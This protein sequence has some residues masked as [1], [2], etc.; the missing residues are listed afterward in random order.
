MKDVFIS[1]HTESA[2]QVVENIARLLEERGVSCWYAPR[3]CEN[4]WADAIV[5]AIDTAEIFLVLLNSGSCNSEHVKN[6]IHVAYEN[7]CH[8]KNRIIAFQLEDQCLSNATIRYY[9]GR[10]HVLNGVFP[11]LDDRI[12]ELVNRVIYIKNHRSEPEAGAECGFFVPSPVTPVVNFVGRRQE[13]SELG[14]LVE[15][16]GKVFVSGMGGIGKSE[17]VR[18]FVSENKKKFSCIMW[19]GFKDSLRSLFVE[20]GVVNIAGF[21]RDPPEESDES[22]FRRKLD[23][24]AKHGRSD[25]LLVIDNFD[26]DGDPDLERIL[27]LPISVI[28]TTRN[29]QYDSEL[30]Y[31]KLKPMQ[32][33][34]DLLTLFGKGYPKR[35]SE[36]DTETVMELIEALGRHT[37]AIRLISNHM[38]QQRIKPEKMLDTVL[39]NVN[40]GSSG[41]GAIYS[42]FEMSALSENERRILINLALIPA[43]G[44]A[45]EELA[46]ALGLDDYEDINALI[47]KSWLVYD[48]ASDYIALHPI[49][50]QLT[51]EKIGYSDEACGNYLQFMTDIARGAKYIE[52]E[53]RGEIT[54]RIE[55][56]LAV[57]PCDSEY[58]VPF[59]LAC[60]QFFHAF[61]RHHKTID[62]MQDIVDGDFDLYTRTEAVTDIADAYRCLHDCDGLLRKADEAWALAEGFAD[63]DER[64]WRLKAEILG[65]Y[66]WYH[67]YR[68]EYAEAYKRFEPQLRYVLKYESDN[69]ERIGW[70]HYN[71]ALALSGDGHLDEAQKEL[72]CALERFREIKMDFAVAAANRIKG[73]LFMYARD[74]ENARSC[75]EESL[76]I[77]VRVVGE[78]H[79][80]TAV[81]MHELAKLLLLLGEVDASRK[82]EDKVRDYCRR[83]GCFDIIPDWI[84]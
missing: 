63:D 11:P 30:C 82:L 24:I 61:S 38:R 70:A 67:L 18:Q 15:T 21:H 35:L 10:T 8:H 25:V 19:G 31:M 44:I 78:D 16:Y 29:Y 68:K 23:Y 3:D 36:S 5:Q 9:L 40:L 32:N 41:F 69:V 76:R 48:S 45:A 14:D 1:Y 51:F 84:E 56:L 52:H 20:D 2:K 54:S 57:L 59:R 22:Y 66:G 26:C 71:V 17:L 7:Y 50:V 62:C 47:G 60:G 33:K 4:M 6:E 43:E 73:E 49:I 79:N 53:R 58:Y 34:E 81:T 13:I 42:I 12:N 39:R 37:L 77:F 55:R 28:F 27:A 64:G 46:D 65:R 83:F 72:E 74:Y 75:L 80:D